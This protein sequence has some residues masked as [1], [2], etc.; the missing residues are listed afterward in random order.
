MILVP[1]SFTADLSGA[2]GSGG[3]RQVKM[4]V[5]NL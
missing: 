1:A 5:G 4:G 2:Q 3:G